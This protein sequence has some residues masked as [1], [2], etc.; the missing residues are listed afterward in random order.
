MTASKVIIM[1]WQ[2]LEWIICP[3]LLAKSFNLSAFL[4]LSFRFRLNAQCKGVVAIY[5]DYIIL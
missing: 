1:F 5:N 3:N 4:D 2:D